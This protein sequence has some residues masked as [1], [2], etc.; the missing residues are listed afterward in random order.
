MESQGALQ[1]SEWFRK[2]CDP[3]QRSQKLLRKL[4]KFVENVVGV[5]DEDI[6]DFSTL[7][8]TLNMNKSLDIDIMFCVLEF[9]EECISEKAMDGDIGWPNVSKRM[10]RDL[11]NP[12]KGDVYP[13]IIQT[14]LLKAEV[15][16]KYMQLL[17]EATQILHMKRQRYLNFL[18][19]S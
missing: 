12:G 7:M 5:L 13:S 14:R 1:D 4:R 19:Q 11:T 8:S 3:T 6:K 10:L 2:L 16:F 15:P 9:F 17:V 18:L